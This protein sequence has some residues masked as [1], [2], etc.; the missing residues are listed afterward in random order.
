[1]AS[2]FRGWRGLGSSGGNTA[3]RTDLVSVRL[4]TTCCL[5]DLVLGLAATLRL[6][7]GWSGVGRGGISWRWLC[8]AVDGGG[9]GVIRRVE[10]PD[11][12]LSRLFDEG[13]RAVVGEHVPGL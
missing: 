3:V 2:W 1:M 10:F 8:L 7:L 4:D 5:V 13:E 12:S 9:S 6:D 11:A